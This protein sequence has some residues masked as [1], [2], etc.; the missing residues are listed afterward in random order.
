[1]S[2]SKMAKTL[3]RDGSITEFADPKLQG[4]YSEEAF[5]FTLELALSCTALNQQRPS[6]EQV[7]KKLEEALLI[8]KGWKVSTTETPEDNV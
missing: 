5:D 8:S 1:M 4:D 2:L 3:T 6:M 7:V